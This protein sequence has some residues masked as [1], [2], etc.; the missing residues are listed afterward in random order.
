MN[1]GG[2]GIGLGMDLGRVESGFGGVAKSAKVP[3]R[4]KH[5]KSVSEGPYILLCDFHKPQ[6]VVNRPEEDPLSLPTRAEQELLL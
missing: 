3:K 4:A 2:I 6:I 5:A 1:F